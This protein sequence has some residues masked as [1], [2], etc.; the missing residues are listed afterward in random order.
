MKQR[1]LIEYENAHFHGG[2][3]NVVV[4]AEGMNDAV[5]R[6]EEFMENSQ[7]ELFTKEYGESVS[8]DEEYADESAV[9]ISS[10]TLLDEKHPYWESFIDKDQAEFYPIIGMPY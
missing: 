5:L 4:W 8:A 2:Y 3:L 10:V 9:S 6:A 7:R 1:Y